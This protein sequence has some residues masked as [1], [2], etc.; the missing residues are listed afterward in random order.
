M[1][2]SSRQNEETD[3][4]AEVAAID[5]DDE[6]RRQ[7]R[8]RTR[9]DTS[10]RVYRSETADGKYDRCEQNQPWYETR[11][12]DGWGPQQQKCPGQPADETQNE[13]A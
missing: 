1:P 13:Q 4:S 9:L 7:G 2:N 5:G 11:E 12:D 8:A 3:A 10:D 6:K